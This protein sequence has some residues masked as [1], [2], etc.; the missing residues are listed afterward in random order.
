MDDDDEEE[1]AIILNNK[2]VQRNTYS[3]SPA[4]GQV[5]IP[6]KS[7]IQAMPAGVGML[8]GSDSDEDTVKDFKIESHMM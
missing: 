6:D 4:T 8:D 1:R 3:A 5:P 7:R 2:T